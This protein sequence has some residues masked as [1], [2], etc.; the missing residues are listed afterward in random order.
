MSYLNYHALEKPAIEGYRIMP[1]YYIQ[2]YDIVSVC[3]RNSIAV[4]INEKESR[5]TSTIMDLAL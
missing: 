3:N 5:C 2:A 4:K 1:M